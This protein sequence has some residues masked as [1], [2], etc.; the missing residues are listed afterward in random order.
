MSIC[1]GGK[2]KSQ[3]HMVFQVAVGARVASVQRLDSRSGGMMRLAQ[4]YGAPVVEQQSTI[5][6]RSIASKDVPW[7][8]V[9]KA[10]RDTAA[11]ANTPPHTLLHSANLPTTDA[12]PRLAAPHVIP[13]LL[14]LSQVVV[15]IAPVRGNQLCF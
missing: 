4:L 13:P 11:V 10:E 5:R 9:V 12:P 6:P 15:L 7:G 8:V 2:T 1:V 3:D 14:P